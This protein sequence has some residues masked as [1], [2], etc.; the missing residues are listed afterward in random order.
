MGGRYFIRSLVHL[1][2]VRMFG[3]LK[4][5][6]KSRL[7]TPVAPAPPA[8]KSK[9]IEGLTVGTGTELS[10]VVDIRKKGGRVKIGN[11]CLVAGMI[12]TER[13]TSIVKIGDNVNVGGGTVIDCVGSITIEDDVLVSYQVVIQDSDNHSVRYSIR[14]NDTRDWLNNQTH[15]WSTTPQKA[16]KIS[17]GAWL[18][19]RSIIL[20]G[21]TIGV[22]SVVAAGSVVTKDVPDWT[23]V[24]GNP[25]R[26][27]R[28]LREDER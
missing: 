2:Q 6:I 4:R 15:D 5:F 21:V 1:Y 14:K 20:K 26:I 18:G 25:A 7:G 17:R 16:V 27:V 13:E 9:L 11:D 22:G 23:I 28:Q 24:A 3:K 8:P 10:G 12:A 19:A